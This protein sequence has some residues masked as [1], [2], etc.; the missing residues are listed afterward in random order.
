MPQSLLKYEIPT[1]SNYIFGRQ[2]YFQNSSCR[3][4]RLWEKKNLNDD[5]EMTVC[6][7]D[8]NISQFIIQNLI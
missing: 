2:D 7:K 5:F 4:L 1:K 6:G 3:L 8:E